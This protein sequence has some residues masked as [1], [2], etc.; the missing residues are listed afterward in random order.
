[1]HAIVQG[2]SGSGKTHLIS[3]IADVLPKEDVLKFTRITESALYN[4]SEDTLVNK[5][6]VIEDLDGLKEEALLA[7]RELVS[8]HQVSSG[9]SIKDKKGNIKS[10]TK[11]VKG[12]FS[13]MSATTKGAVYEDNMNRSFLLAVDESLAQTRKVIAYQNKRYAGEISREMRTASHARTPT[14]Y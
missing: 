14:I 13:S 2:S 3:K 8:N 9:V 11:L 12:I 4:F 1:M 5:L 7:F 10:T 6:V